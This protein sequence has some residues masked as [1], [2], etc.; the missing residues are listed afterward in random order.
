MPL[1]ARRLLSSKVNKICAASRVLLVAVCYIYGLVLLKDEKSH[2]FVNPNSTHKWIHIAIDYVILIALPA[3][4][5]IIANII[6]IVCVLRARVRNTSL[7]GG[8]SSAAVDARTRSLVAMLIAISVA[9][10]I[11]KTPYHL[12][13]FMFDTDAV[14][15]RSQHAKAIVQ[16]CFS[17]GIFMQYFNHSINFYL[18]ILSGNEFKAE[19]MFLLGAIKTRI[20]RALC[21]AGSTD[22]DEVISQKTT[23]TDKDNKKTT[24]DNLNIA[25]TGK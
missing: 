25:N 5:I 20:A 22:V 10:V 14:H 18:Y 19:L 21:A 7:T 17:V 9:F 1:R 4:A 8:Q 12:I 3:I 23:M 11:L 16:L 15:R 13:A 24:F 6:L 2:C